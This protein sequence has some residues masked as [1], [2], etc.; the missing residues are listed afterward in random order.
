MI[1]LLDTLLLGL[2][3]ILAVLIFTQLIVPAFN[4]TRLL[5]WFR[6]TPLMREVEATK[7]QVETLREQTAA[8][9][10]LDDLIER[11]QGLEARIAELQNHQTKS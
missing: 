4:G 11:K 8:L 7:E 3:L 5:P 2:G 6:P 1:V 10:E 9:D